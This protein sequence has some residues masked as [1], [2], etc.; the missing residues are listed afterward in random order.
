M[1]KSC[2]FSSDLIRQVLCVFRGM[3]IVGQPTLPG[4]WSLIAIS[5]YNH[6]FHPMFPTGTCYG[7]CFPAAKECM[8]NQ[9]VSNLGMVTMSNHVKIF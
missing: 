3:G 7:D 1:V 8:D 9:E 6:S 5:Q 4:Q 2:I